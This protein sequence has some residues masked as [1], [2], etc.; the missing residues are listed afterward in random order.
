M[1]KFDSPR[2]IELKKQLSQER[3]RRLLKDVQRERERQQKLDEKLKVAR[4]RD[5]SR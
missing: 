1:P 2:E 4:K 5:A 3:E